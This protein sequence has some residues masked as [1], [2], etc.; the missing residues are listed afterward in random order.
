MVLGLERLRYHDYTR[1]LGYIVWGLG[2]RVVVEQNFTFSWI[3]GPNIN[4]TRSL[5]MEFQQE[6]SLGLCSGM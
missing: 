5:L 2:F 1:Q 4:K 3:P 6:P